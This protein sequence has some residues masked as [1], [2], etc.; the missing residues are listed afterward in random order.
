[1]GVRGV[2]QDASAEN[3]VERSAAKRVSRNICLYEKELLITCKLDGG[4][5]NGV[6]DVRGEN[7]ASVGGDRIRKGAVPA[8]RIQDDLARQFL[9][10]NIDL[11]REKAASSLDGSSPCLVTFVVEVRPLQ[12]EALADFL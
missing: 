8:A 2:V 3:D 11:L 10:S 1:M 6:A 7:A 9:G 12:A 5:L 4:T